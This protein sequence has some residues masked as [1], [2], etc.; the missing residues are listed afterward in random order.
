[1]I[2]NLEEDKTIKNVFYNGGSAVNNG[3]VSNTLGNIKNKRFLIIRY[4]HD[5]CYSYLILKNPISAYN[6]SFI[7]GIL[8]T[9]AKITY[10]KDTDKLTLDNNGGFL[11]GLEYSDTVF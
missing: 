3:T 5:Y 4:I 8:D 11:A 1:M 2:A 9:N 10:N 7:M 6:T